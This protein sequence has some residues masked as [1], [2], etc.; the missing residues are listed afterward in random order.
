M[1]VG[2]AR[3]AARMPCIARRWLAI[4]PP[5]VASLIDQSTWE[6]WANGPNFIGS[7]YLDP[8]Y[9]PDV[10]YVSFGPAWVNIDWLTIK[11]GDRIQIRS[12][13]DATLYQDWVATEEFVE[14]Y[15]GG[16]VAVGGGGPLIGL[17]RLTPVEV[18]LTPV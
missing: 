2:F 11:T 5:P 3:L 7:A 10:L 6:T 8:V 4:L 17:T 1:N 9:D 12:P 16:H 15:P 14:A 18:V 13:D